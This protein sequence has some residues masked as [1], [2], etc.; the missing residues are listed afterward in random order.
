MEA[1]ESPTPAGETT[2]TVSF[3]GFCSREFFTPRAEDPVACPHCRE[4]DLARA[5]EI[6]CVMLQRTPETLRLI[7]AADP[8]LEVRLQR[9]A[10]AAEVVLDCAR[11]AVARYHKTA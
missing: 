9:E 1:I 10:D 3:C 2:G 7:V 11:L 8:E 4:S 6:V 5:L